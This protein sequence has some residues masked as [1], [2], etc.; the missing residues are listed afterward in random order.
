MRRIC[1]TETNCVSEFSDVME[2]KH[3]WCQKHFGCVW[4][5]HS[6]FLG[7]YFNIL[8][9]MNNLMI[10]SLMLTEREGQK[11]GA[12]QSSECILNIVITVGANV[13]KQEPCFNIPLMTWDLCLQRKLHQGFSLP[14]FSE[15]FLSKPWVVMQCVL[16]PRASVF[17]VSSLLN[18]RNENKD[19]EGDATM[20]RAFLCLSLHKPH[21]LEWYGPLTADERPPWGVSSYVSSGY[22][23]W[24]VLSQAAGFSLQYSCCCRIY[25]HADSSVYY[26]PDFTAMQP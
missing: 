25:S 18:R 24:N 1:V 5:L 19:V 3:S 20:L 22:P 14:L 15:W 23:F 8:S 9:W 12:A 17:S 10:L 4:I 11:R 6:S 13:R 7:I 2:N 16:S 21:V 26:V